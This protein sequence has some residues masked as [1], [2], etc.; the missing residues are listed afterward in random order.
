MTRRQIAIVVLIVVV[1]STFSA[2]VAYR[3]GARRP[4]IRGGDALAASGGKSGCADIKDAGS[5]TGETGCVQGRIVRVFASR[6]GNTFLDFCTD[7]RNC[8]FTSVIFSSDRS[9]FG[10]LNAL[11]GHRVEL[12]GAITTYDGRAEIVVRE[13]AQLRVLP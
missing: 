2:I 3:S 13:P 7:Y 6:V 10:D 4:G 11:A 5:H 9:K 8:P 1:A 12:E